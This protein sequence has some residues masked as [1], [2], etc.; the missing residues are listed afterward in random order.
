MLNV[1]C[2]MFNVN[3]HC[4]RRF[5]WPSR[6]REKHGT[7]GNHGRRPQDQLHRCGKG[8][9]DLSR[10]SDRGTRRKIS[11]SGRCAYLLLNGSLP[12]TGELQKFEK[13]VTAAREVPTYVYSGMKDCPKEQSLWMSFRRVFL[14][15]PWLTRNLQRRAG[16]G[17]RQDGDPADRSNAGGSRGVAS[18]PKRA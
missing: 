9:P 15:L 14:C 2:S 8:C 1:Q 4:P 12:G 16:V 11:L 7:A 6:Q 5:T 13:E 18:H 10:L 17:R 3:D